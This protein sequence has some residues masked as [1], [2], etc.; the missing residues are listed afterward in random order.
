MLCD[1]DALRVDV[2]TISLYD[3]AVKYEWDEEKNQ[4]NIHKHGFDFADAE[5]IF[6]GPMVVNADTREDYG[7]DRWIGMG[8]FRG[9][10]VAVVFTESAPDIIRIISIRKALKYERRHYEKTLKDGLGL[11]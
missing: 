6:G 4:I 9:R 8:D 11:D 5:E 2:F 7:E 3:E 1:A 10:V